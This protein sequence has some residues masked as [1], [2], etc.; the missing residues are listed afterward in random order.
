MLDKR[1]R[2]TAATIVD[3]KRQQRALAAMLSRIASGSASPPVD[4]NLW[5]EMLKT[6]GMGPRARK[7]W[8]SEFER[9]APEAHNEFLLSL[10]IPFEEVA[11]IRR[12]SRGEVGPEKRPMLSSDAVVRPTGY[13]Q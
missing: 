8:H 13:V 7:R 9:R 2:E 4:V 5:V 11:R 12:W 1:M 6:A 3:L 10:G